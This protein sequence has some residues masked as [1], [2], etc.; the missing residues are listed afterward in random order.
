MTE[1]EFVTF[2]SDFI[3]EHG[4]RAWRQIMADHKVD[5]LAEAIKHRDEIAKT[6]RE[7]MSA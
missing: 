7:L 2:V 1:S 3:L 6:M 5:T 4:R